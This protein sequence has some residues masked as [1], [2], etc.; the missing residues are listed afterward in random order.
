MAGLALLP[1]ANDNRAPDAPHVSRRALLRDRG[2]LAVLA[3]ASLIQGSHAVYYGFSSLQWRS[4]G[5]DGASIAA[6]W[7]IGVLAEIVLFAFQG[8]LAMSPTGL[9]LLGAFGGLVRWGVM[10][11]DPPTAALPFLQILHA[12]SFG[13]THLGALTYVAR[14]AGEGQAATAQGHLAIALSAVM[15]AASA[16]SGPLYA[17]YGVASYAAMALMAIA[18][19][20]AARIA[21]RAGAVAHMPRA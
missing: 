8:R 3:A 12:L 18:G 2:F 5:L 15:A 11:I 1:V 4:D 17:R 14:R 6:L 13:A 10:M 9:L 20:V 7:A 19:G 16:I 21:G